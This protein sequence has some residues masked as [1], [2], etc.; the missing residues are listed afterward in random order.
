MFLVP[1]FLVLF[2]ALL[3]WSAAQWPGRP[4]AGVA[5]DVA[6]G[7]FVS[8]EI[9][10]E[11]F[12]VIQQTL[13]EAQT[14]ASPARG[15]IVLSAVLLGLL[16]LATSVWMVAWTARGGDWDWGPRHMGRM[17]RWDR[18]TAGSTLQSDAAEVAVQIRDF[19]YAPRSIEI[20]VGARVTWT[21]EDAVPHS[22]TDRARRWDTGVLSKGAAGSTTFGEPG[23]FAYYCTVHPS[24][25][26]AVIV[27]P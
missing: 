19:D 7:R 27:R 17:M 16:F 5:V 23:S 11:Q 26:G 18:V 15:F 3:A 8:G 21:N 13:G 6:R 9:S 25:T 10:E 2:V 24:M 12:R 14:A 4:S 20:L 22:A 1:L